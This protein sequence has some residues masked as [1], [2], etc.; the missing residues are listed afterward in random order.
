MD[1]STKNRDAPTPD[2]PDPDLTHNKPYKDWKQERQHLR[3][4]WGEQGRQILPPSPEP[5]NET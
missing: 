2:K 1:K 4:K 3:D 5:E